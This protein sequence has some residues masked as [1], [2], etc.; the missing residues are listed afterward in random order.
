MRTVFKSI[1]YSFLFLSF[2]THVNAQDMGK[3]IEEN[4]QFAA[5]QYKV[6]AKNTPKD[7]MPRSYNVKEN[8]F[9]DS[10]TDWWTSGFYPGTLWYI[11]E[12]TQDK[13]ILKEAEH[14][15]SILEKEKRY[16]GNHDIGFMIFCSFGNAYRITKD[17]K[18]RPT[19]D[20]AA[21]TLT[22]RYKPYVRA[23]RSW[24]WGKQFSCPVIIDNMMNLELLCWVS[25]RTNNPIYRNIAVDHANTTMK[26][27]FRPD[28]S[29]YHV[30]DYDL[31][32]GKVRQ[33]VTW[34]GFS[35]DS[36]WARGQGWALYG[37]TMMYRM[38]KDHK[39][40]EQAKNVANFIINHPN[41]PEDG[42]PYWDFN[43]PKIPNSLR[44][45]SA[46]SLIASALLELGTFAPDKQKEYVAKAELILRSLSS[47]KYRA[48]YGTNGGFILEHSV[49][50]F[51]FNSE[52]DVPLTYADYYFVE[53]LKRY[54]DW[55]LN[56]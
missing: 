44:D 1:F 47:D 38:V 45:V 10:K 46:G 34:Q 52:V 26:N 4:F 42:V 40:L 28:Y 27:H 7:M 16:T 32:T 15:L 55:Y 14:R 54:K 48:K 2:V 51:P 50:G 18:Y 13:E 43:D 23:I 39:Y 35:D 25:D 36:A 37:Y 20:T 33:K 12:Q 30:V 6:L 41:L 5:K 22:L 53:A 21:M 8:K 29:S 9:I 17:E 49:G 19:I 11:Y 3:I 24:D 56:K 31:N